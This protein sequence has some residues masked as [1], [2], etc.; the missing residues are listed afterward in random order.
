MW[1][2]R[3]RKRLWAILRLL[4]RLSS[5]L[6]VTEHT[7]P[8]VV[9]L[10]DLGTLLDADRHDNLYD[11]N[12]C[13]HFSILCVWESVPFWFPPSRMVVTWLPWNSGPE[14]SRLLDQL[15][16]A[17][18]SVVTASKVSKLCS[19]RTVHS[20]NSLAQASHS[21]NVK[22]SNTPVYQGVRRAAPVYVA[23]PDVKHSD[24][25]VS[26][27]ACKDIVT[28]VTRNFFVPQSLPLTACSACLAAIWNATS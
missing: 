4:H 17:M 24:G 10:G 6:D 25:P 26:T 18:L 16:I 27:R 11:C 1:A 13:V 8:A 7:V 23:L 3:P 5:V 2:T 20:A 9:S 12:L 21:C 22:T 14:S 19:F 15:L 28:S